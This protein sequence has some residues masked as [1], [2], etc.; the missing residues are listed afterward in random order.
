MPP[1]PMCRVVASDAVDRELEPEE[2]EERD[3]PELG[4]ELGHLGGLDEAEDLRLVGPEQDPGEQVSRDRREPE[5]ARHET[6]RR[7]DGDGGGELLERHPRV[8]L[9]WEL[10]AKSYGGTEDEASR[11]PLPRS[12]AFVAETRSPFRS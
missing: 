2:E 6:E 3:D 12:C 5:T 8:I 4:H 1:I 9:R 10:R 11:S 7:E